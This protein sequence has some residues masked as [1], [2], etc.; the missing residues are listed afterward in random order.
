MRFD[1]DNIKDESNF[2]KHGIRFVDAVTVFA[3]P[4]LL[5]TEDFKHSQYEER[6]WA[7]GEMENGSI[8]VVVFTIRDEII[9]II[10]A[11]KA[12]KKERK[13]YEERI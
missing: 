12:T 7:I 9:R 11:R 5:F 6:E 2:L 1:W 8:V 10:S 13:Q 4:F 3:D